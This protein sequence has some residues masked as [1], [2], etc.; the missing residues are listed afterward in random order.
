[1][2]VCLGLYRL[3][4][5]FKSINIHYIKCKFFMVINYNCI[6]TSFFFFNSIVGSIEI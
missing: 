3:M 6:F 1:M 4:S 2:L 5:F